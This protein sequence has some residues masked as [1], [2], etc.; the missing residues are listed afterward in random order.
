LNN[1][2]EALDARAFWRS[3]VAQSDP[4]RLEG[5]YTRKWEIPMDWKIATAGSCFAQHIS[6][7]LARGGF[8]VIDAE[9]A[10]WG[11]PA[12]DHRRF[13]FSMYSARYGN[14]YTLR[15]LV[16][17][18][19][20]VAGTHTPGELCWEKGDR[21]FDALRPGVEPE[22]LDS[23]D[24]VLLHRQAHLESVR[25]V[26]TQMDLLI[27]TLG[28][29]E[30]WVHRETGTVF[31]TVPG[32]IAGQF[33]PDLYAFWNASFAEIM[34]DFEALQ[35]L[36]LS[37][38]GEKGLP[39]FLLTVSPV[40]LTAT[41]SGEHVLQA[42]THSKSVLRAVAGEL[43]RAHAHIDYFPS[44]EIITN[45]A[46]GGGFYADNLRSVRT[47]GVEAVMELFFSQ[48]GGERAIYTPKTSDANE[49]DVACEEALLEAFGP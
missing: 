11:L 14:I 34:E 28:L 24:A 9:P 8:D 20:E 12:A 3:A 4:T 5:L 30:T 31:P 42:T 23:A 1:P 25:E 37:I 15:Q 44:F 36:L 6:R 21:F 26:L 33:D 18:V 16:Q 19:G 46:A 47:E 29:T 48:H 35:Q 40:P 17:L 49:D 32:G 7:Y 41:A 27:F 2:Y 22:G 38:R 45:P 13:G 39:R 43:A 10:P